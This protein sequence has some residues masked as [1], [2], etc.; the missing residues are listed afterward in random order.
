MPLLDLTINEIKIQ[1]GPIKNIHSEQ[2]IIQYIKN[3]GEM[4][5]F[6]N[7]ILFYQHSTINASVTKLVIKL[8]DYPFELI[9]LHTLSFQSQIVSVNMK[10]SYHIDNCV[11]TYFDGSADVG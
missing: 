10:S 5:Y 11:Y 9:N 1:L 4:D 6:S 8:R 2:S 3:I 7:E